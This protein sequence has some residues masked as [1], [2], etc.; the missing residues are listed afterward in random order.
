MN[1]DQKNPYVGPRSFRKEEAYLFHGRDREARDLNSLVASE[2]LVLFYAQSGAGKS[3]LVN[4]SL[5]P[6]LET[7]KYEVFRIGRV[8]G[9]GFPAMDVENIYI[10]NLMR[11]LVQQEIDLTL[12]NG[13]C[14]KDFLDGLKRNEQ[15]YFFEGI[16]S[17]NEMDGPKQRRALIIDQFEEIFTTHLPA[18]RKRDGFFQQLAQAMEADPFLTV[19]LIMRED[20]IASLDPYAYLLPGELRVRYYM[21]RLRREA[22]LWA[23]QKPVTG[24][25]PYAT[26]VAEKLVDDLA[27]ITYQNPDGT[28]EVYPGQYVEP[29]QLQV[30]CYGLWENLPS[31]GS[32]I[33][34]N[35]ILDVGDV[36]QS[37][38]RFYDR[39]VA[40]VAQ[41]K[42]VPERSIREW[43]ED[44]LITNAKMRNMVLQDEDTED[45]LPDDV[46][47]AMQGDL[48]R[49]ELRAGQIWYELSH[50]RLIDPVINSNIKWF[51]KHLSLFQRRVLIWVEQGKSESL[52]LRGE[53]LKNTEKEAQSLSLTRDEQE[54]LEACKAL[55]KREQRDQSQR[56]VIFIAFIIS[57][58][59]LIAAII[60][61]IN[62]NSSK[63]QANNSKSTAVVAMEKAVNQ[64]HIAFIALTERAYAQAAQATESEDKLRTQKS[65]AGNLA[66]Q[67]DSLKNSDHVLALLL[68]LE[69]F[70][71]ADD[72]ATRE[73]TRPE[74]FNLLQFT[75][76]KKISDF[77]GAVNAAAVSPDGEL[78][79]IASCSKEDCTNRGEI[80]LYDRNLK[81]LGKIPGE[82]GIVQSLAFYQ[83][84]NPDRLVLAAGGCDL[85]GCKESGQVIFWEIT[86]EGDAL[87]LS[88]QNDHDNLVKTITFRPDG[89]MLA[90]GSYDTTISLWDIRDLKNPQKTDAKLN[91]ASYVMD[92]AFSPDG[93]YIVSAGNDGRVYVWQ[94]SNDGEQYEKI[95]VIRHN[96]KL[97][98]PVTSVAFSPDGKTVASAGFDNKIRLWD[99]NRR[100][101]IPRQ[102]KGT[103]DGHTRSITSLDFISDELIASAGFDN[104][105]ILWNVK[106][107]KQVGPPLAV[108]TEPINQVVNGPFADNPFLISVS[109]DHTAIRWDI[110]TR[111][112]VSQSLEFFA[113]E[114]QALLSKPDAWWNEIV[115]SAAKRSLT[116]AERN[117]YI[118]G[119]NLVSTL[120]PIPPLP[121]FTPIPTATRFQVKSWSDCS[122]QAVF[123]I[124][125][126]NGDVISIF[127]P[128]SGTARIYRLGSTNLSDNLPEGYTYESG[129][130]LDILQ[131][132]EPIPVISEGGYIKLSFV[133]QPGNNYTVLYWDPWYWDPWL[134]GN[135]N[136]VNNPSGG[137]WV[138]L[139]D[140]LLDG[141][142]NLESLPLYPDTNDPRTV[143]SGVKLVN[144]NGLE[145]IEVSTNFPGIFVLAQH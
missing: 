89:S 27:K 118:S 2:Q 54:F 36:D 102:A 107:G 8:S 88:Q 87:L 120:T 26:G 37:L 28:R 49:A 18:W 131:Q 29:V 142:G 128:I 42:N 145:R 127:C 144:E 79:A 73:I 130:K 47:Q 14:L 98:A 46:I 95:Q 114:N 67:A 85:K 70:N 19:I 110:L 140:F 122:K 3:S 41:E 83:Y 138:P 71:M 121:T 72:T 137:S 116:E 32:E 44:K 135:G 11:S 111:N 57:V 69:A 105:V 63:E 17:E 113:P 51:E 6:H 81:E 86:N 143:I 1:T 134:N 96:E 61:T 20:Y 65:L 117:M 10:F 104:Q 101:L 93:N 39:R 21:Q 91:H 124:Q 45:G 99:W 40:V 108:H 75:P 136:L 66:A 56:R 16:S 50:D 23:V 132:G 74:L 30:V 53:E 125:F 139:K 115:Y 106:T 24:I 31:E 38:E 123:P 4:T 15:G 34:E 35:D 55:K 112:P 13:L 5:V 7:K 92:I 62:A 103:L 9:E 12:L 109:N 68:G 60:A 77:E 52:L 33:T 126:G 48:L 58:V 22:A 100:S 82:Y 76:Y 133:A 25:R 94:V 80:Q 43:F 78:I 64:Q 119:I 97:S 59:L 129:F 141:N 84:E 90:A